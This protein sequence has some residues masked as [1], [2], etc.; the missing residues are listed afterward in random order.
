MGHGGYMDALLDASVQLIQVGL[1]LL[2]AMQNFGIRT[3]LR[4][5]EEKLAK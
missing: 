5:I 2:L 3:R 4:R 1:L